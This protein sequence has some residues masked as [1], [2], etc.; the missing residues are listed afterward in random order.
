VVA[1]RHGNGARGLVVL[2][3]GLGQ[4]HL[5]GPAL[6]VVDGVGEQVAQDAFDAPGV[7]L[8]GDLVVGYVD[9]DGTAGRVGDGVHLFGGPLD[10]RAQVHHLGRQFLH[11][12]VEPGDLEQVGQQLLEPV[13][14]VGE[15]LGGACQSGGEL[16]AG[17]VQHV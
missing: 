17:G 14:F 7:D 13:E 10:D 8:G 15:Q 6:P 4:A 1:D 9:L 16:F 12:R 5:H 11:A 3:A 2:L